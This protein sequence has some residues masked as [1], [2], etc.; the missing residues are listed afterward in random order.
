MG[1]RL[2]GKMHDVSPG[3]VLTL[4][5]SGRLG[6]TELLEADRRLKRSDW[7]SNPVIDAQLSAVEA[8]ARSAG[9]ESKLPREEKRRVREFEEIL[10]SFRDAYPAMQ[11]KM[12]D[13]LDRRSSDEGGEE[14]R[15]GRGKKAKDAKSDRA[16]ADRLI[17]NFCVL[18]GRQTLLDSQ[19]PADEPV[20]DAIS[21]C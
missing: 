21:A 3:W 11:K 2:I 13:D 8:D 15:E 10:E 5:A 18:T 12:L 16:L 7:P 9:I 19:R 6:V 20:L 17:V 14:S 1:R 4:E